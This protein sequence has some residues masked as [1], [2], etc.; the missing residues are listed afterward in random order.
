MKTLSF[1]L[2]KEFVLIFRNPVMLFMIIMMPVIQL[3]ILPW[4]ATFEQRDI[5]LAI[6]DNDRSALSN[7]LTEKLAASTHFSLVEYVSSY[8]QAFQGIESG[9]SSIILELPPD[10][11]KAL[12]CERELKFMVDIDAVNGQRAG[13]GLSY[14]SQIIGQYVQ[15]VGAER[16][17]VG[18]PRPTAPQIVIKPQYR[19]NPTLGY[20]PFMVPG[21]LVILITTVAGLLSAQNIV[22][23]KETGTIEQINVTPVPRTVFILGKIIPFWVIGFVI[24][25]LGIVIIR[26]VYGVIPHGNLLNLYLVTAFY[27]LAFT[28]VGIIVSNI[29]STQQQAMLITFFVLMLCVLL[30]GLFTPISSM[31]EWAQTLTKF[32]PLTYFVEIIRL[33]YLKGSSF[34]DI[35]PQILKL[36]LFAVVLNV[37]AVLSYR[38][39][40]S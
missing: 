6:I 23:E 9:Y 24:L 7:R 25:S 19:Y 22:H 1:L 30:S 16:G 27:V 38:K 5:R 36:M 39:T 33:I 17:A 10:F 29:A 4:V 2:E 11:E 34:L 8:E 12:I 15:Q 40:S 37:V 31:P 26:L 28:G 32:N 20:Y 3:L 14:V 18:K 35:L 13:V 21:I